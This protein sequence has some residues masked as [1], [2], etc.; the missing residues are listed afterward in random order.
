MPET[1]SHHEVEETIERNG[2]AIR[3][4][5]EQARVLRE[6]RERS[7]RLFKRARASL[8]RWTERTRRAA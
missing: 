8:E 1:V 7:R 2:Q 6:R 3:R 4:G 5:D